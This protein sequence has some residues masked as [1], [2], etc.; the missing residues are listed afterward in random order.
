VGDMAKNGGTRIS[1]FKGREARL[2][3]AILL[4]LSHESPL[5]IRQVYKRVR[6]HKGLQHVRYRV[7]NRRMKALEKEGYIEQVGKEKTPQG[8]VAK[9]YQTTFRAFLA[10]AL[11]CIDLNEFVRA[12]DESELVTMLAVLSS[13]LELDQKVDLMF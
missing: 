12:A 10:F 1:V 2:N 6:T 8:F 3:R 13:M 7:V 9:L 11:Y 5:N 4:I